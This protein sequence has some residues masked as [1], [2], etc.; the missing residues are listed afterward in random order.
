MIKSLLKL[1]ILVIFAAVCILTCPDKEA[2]KEAVNAMVQD[3]LKQE[4]RAGTD[5]NIEYAAGEFFGNLLT[6]AA[7][8]YSLDVKNYVVCSV[9]KMDI[10]GKSVTVSFGILGHVFPLS[11]NPLTELIDKLK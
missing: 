3:K 9:G 6:K 2:H 4:L 1:L 8:E 10:D 5:N 7:V 11:S